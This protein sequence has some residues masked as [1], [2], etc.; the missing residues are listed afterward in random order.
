MH[1]AGA[2]VLLDSQNMDTYLMTMIPGGFGN[3][4]SGKIA[5]SNEVQL[6]I[7]RIGKS[8]QNVTISKKA[9][10][11]NEPNRLKNNQIELIRKRE[12]EEK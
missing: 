9:P 3:S 8:L 11:N 1:P 7:D 6:N 12:S 4:S 5:A 2:K 10:L